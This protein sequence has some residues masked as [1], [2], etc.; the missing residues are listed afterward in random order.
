MLDGEVLFSVH[1]EEGKPEVSVLGDGPEFDVEM[2][3]I[4]SINGRRYR[5]VHSSTQDFFGEPRKVVKI[6]RIAW[7]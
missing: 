1:D 2:G 5:V 3:T 4:L 6:Q 7:N